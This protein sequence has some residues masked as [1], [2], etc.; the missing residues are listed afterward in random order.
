[1]PSSKQKYDIAFAGNRTRD[2]CLEGRYFTTK[3]RMLLHSSGVIV[4]AVGV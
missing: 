1:M 3:L 4:G 2:I